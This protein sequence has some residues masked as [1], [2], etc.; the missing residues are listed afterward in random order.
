MSSLLSLLPLAGCGF[1]MWFCMRGMRGKKS[2]MSEPTRSA[3]IE[4]LRAEVSRLRA[5]LHLRAGT[6][7]RQTLDQ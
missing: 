6:S 1:M 5:E 4:Q 2:A 3:E 7:D